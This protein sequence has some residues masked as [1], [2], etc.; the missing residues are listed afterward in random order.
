MWFLD[1]NMVFDA[2]SG[3]V[4][5]KTINIEELI[6]ML[7]MPGRYEVI[8]KGSKGFIILPIS[9]DA[10]LITPEGHKEAMEYFRPS[11]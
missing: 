8:S 11:T 2:M 9:K 5:L 7:L 4:Q 6:K 1:L 3:D 10:L